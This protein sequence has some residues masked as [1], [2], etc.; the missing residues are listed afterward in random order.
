MYILRHFSRPFSDN[1]YMPNSAGI[2]MSHAIES[3][4]QQLLI[5]EMQATAE[6]LNYMVRI[7]NLAFKIRASEEDDSIPSIVIDGFLYHG[8]LGHASNMQLLR[9]LDIRHIINTCDCPLPREIMDNLNV[10]WINIE[11]DFRTNVSRHFDE[12][13][14]F[15]TS[16]EEKSEKVLVH[17]QAGVSRS[18]SVVLAYLIKYDFDSVYI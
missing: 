4:T 13:N 11:D 9:S 14:K 12:T 3:T 16:C 15:L 17:C 1:M 18:S 8:D 10:L 2:P 7:L 6:E 5:S